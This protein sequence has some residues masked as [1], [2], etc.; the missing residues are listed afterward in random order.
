MFIQPLTLSMTDI[1]LD[2]VP[3]NL[4]MSLGCSPCKWFQILSFDIQLQIHSMSTIQNMKMIEM[5]I[6]HVLKNGIIAISISLK[7]EKNQEHLYD[8]E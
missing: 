8:F 2:S 6:L 7:E 1:S 4:C 3:L 5:F